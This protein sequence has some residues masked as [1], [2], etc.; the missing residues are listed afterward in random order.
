MTYSR[1]TSATWLLIIHIYHTYML[2]YLCVSFLKLIYKEFDT[3]ISIYANINYLYFYYKRY[4][5]KILIISFD[6]D[7]K[8]ISYNIIYFLN[9]YYEKIT[10]IEK[11]YALLKIYQL[12]PE[13][14]ESRT[15]KHHS[16]ASVPSSC[17][18]VNMRKWH[19]LSSVT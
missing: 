6:F 1:D 4:L 12:S 18:I 16:H 13:I 5:I 2:V 15:K 3:Q 9:N 19:H 11:T 14:S 7:N 8:N 10:Y 17:T